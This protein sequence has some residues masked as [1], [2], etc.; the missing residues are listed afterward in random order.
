MLVHGVL[1]LLSAIILSRSATLL[2]KTLQKI[3]SYLRLSQFVVGFILMAVATSLPEL[4][5]GITSAVAG[6]PTLALGTV[7]GS[8]IANLTLVIGLAA[9]S[10]RGIRIEPRTSDR[11]IF[12][13]AISACAP[14]ILLWDG[15]LSRTEGV[16]LLLFFA[17]YMYR[18]ITEGERYTKKYKHNHHNATTI[19]KVLARF[20]V[21]IVFL[22]GSAH[23]LVEN[24]IALAKD[25]NLPLVLVG[26]FI[27]A[28]G[29][30]L[31]ELAFSI[32]ALIKRQSGMVFGNILG[33]V[34]TNATLILGVTAV[35]RPIQITHHSLFVVSSFFLTAVLTLFILFVRSHRKL[36]WMEG[37]GLIFIY[38]LFVILEFSLEGQL[39]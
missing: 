7:I 25:L 27:V 26:L 35:I 22:I 28:I 8:N 33:S 18:L 19:A 24:S 10:A 15:T 23:I 13:M 1:F 37:L 21:G 4:L 6:E 9:V 16:A 38:I 39:G 29:T 17:L 5:V 11:D 36:S 31:P 20:A 3:S 30:S 14:I 34:A 32:P 12:Y 2:I